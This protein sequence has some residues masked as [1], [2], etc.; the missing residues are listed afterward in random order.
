MTVSHVSVTVNHGRR[1]SLN[2][3]K[4]YFFL[5]YTETGEQKKIK[6]ITTGVL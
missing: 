1:F 6:K 3:V 2:K 5:L 4:K